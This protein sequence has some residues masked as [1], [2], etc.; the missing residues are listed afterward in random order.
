MPAKPKTAFATFDGAKAH[1]YVYERA[2]KRL[3]ALPGF[4]LS[5]D[6]KLRF[7]DQR[8]RE[9]SSA[10]SQ[11]NTI[12]PQTDPEKNMERAFVAEIAKQLE[13][14]RTQRAF[15]A[16]VVSAAPRALG[17]WREV[18]PAPLREATAK[19]L[20]GVYGNTPQAELVAIIEKA[21][22]PA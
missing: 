5:G 4:P 15:G 21:L 6:R 20:N 12:E 13:T 3:T 16:L 10:G 2:E 9:F 18:A 7:R 8:P 1:A 19:E 14:L 22:A 17:Y 11:R